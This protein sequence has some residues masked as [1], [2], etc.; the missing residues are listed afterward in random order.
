MVD[1]PI[2]LA[3]GDDG[4]VLQP[5]ISHA[6]IYKKSNTKKKIRAYQSK[7]CSSLSVLSVTPYVTNEYAFSSMCSGVKATSAPMGT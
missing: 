1:V 4:E 5:G 2:V 3:D 7:T 6:F